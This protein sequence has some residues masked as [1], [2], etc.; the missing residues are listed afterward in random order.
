[1]KQFFLMNF[2]KKI[3]CITDE[4]SAL[5]IQISYPDIKD[6]EAVSANKFVAFV[7]DL[8]VENLVQAILQK[9]FKSFAKHFAALLERGQKQVKSTYKLDESFTTTKVIQLCTDYYSRCTQPDQ[10][11]GP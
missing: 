3:S 10:D 9:Q 8:S 2:L 4:P 1:M 11:D 7:M 5:S 6:L